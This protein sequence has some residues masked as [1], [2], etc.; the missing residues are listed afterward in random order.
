MDSHHEEAVQTIVAGYL[1]QR[2]SFTS[3]DVCNEAKGQGYRVRN[4]V[5]SEWLREN[6]TKTAHKTGAQ[7]NST[8]VNVDSK[9]DGFT[10]AYLYHH[11][12]VDADDYMDRDQNPQSFRRQTPV[13]QMSDMTRVL[14]TLKNLAAKSDKIVFVDDGNVPPI[15]ASALTDLVASRTKR[16]QPKPKLQKRDALGR[17][18]SGWED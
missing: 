14:Y 12:E 17:Y 2:R 4:R 1:A 10:Q 3:V 18:I 13:R 9:A 16:V 5:V 7:Y 6:F 11:F 15:P 8:L